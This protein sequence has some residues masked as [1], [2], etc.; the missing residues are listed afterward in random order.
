MCSK[1]PK[2]LPEPALVVNLKQYSILCGEKIT[3]FISDM[4]EWDGPILCTDTLCGPHQ[5]GLWQKLM[6]YTQ[7]QLLILEP[8]N[9]QMHCTIYANWETITSLL[10]G[11]D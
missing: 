11:V 10:L 2:Q 6:S 4:L 5:K 3:I 7:W 1:G 8:E 9:F